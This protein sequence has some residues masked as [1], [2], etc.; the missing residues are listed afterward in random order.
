M[1][2]TPI[3]SRRG[4]LAPKGAT[5]EADGTYTSERG[6]H[7]AIYLDPD[8]R[9]IRVYDRRR[10]RPVHERLIGFAG[11]RSGG[12]GSGSTDG[13]RLAAGG[14]APPAGAAGAR[15]QVEL[16]AVAQGRMTSGNM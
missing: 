7:A 3:I 8:G 9:G 5:S 15:A 14:C 2:S 10:G 1:L 13:E 16:P 6:N 4:W 11:D 12:R